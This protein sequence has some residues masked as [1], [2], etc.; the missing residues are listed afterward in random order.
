MGVMPRLACLLA[1]VLIAANGWCFATC[2]VSVEAPVMHCHSHGST[3]TRVCPHANSA[4]GVNAPAVAPA[5]AAAMPIEV[6]A[7][8]L[9]S[10]LRLRPSISPSPPVQPGCAISLRI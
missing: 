2:S 1:I 8:A 7:R 5:C 10:S 9:L 4:L 3:D 6:P